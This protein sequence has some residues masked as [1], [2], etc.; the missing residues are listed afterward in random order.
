MP[1]L[2]RRWMTIWLEFRVALIN[3]QQINPRVSAFS[4]VSWSRF[5]Q[6]EGL[7]VDEFSHRFIVRIFRIRNVNIPVSDDYYMTV[8]R[9][10]WSKYVYELWIRV[11]NHVKRSIYYCHEYRRRV[12][13]P[14]STKNILGF[15]R[16]ASLVADL[17]NTFDFRLLRM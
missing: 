13:L 3:Q 8:F 16:F 11:E 5:Y 2:E 15:T 12:S 14:H 10:T 6:L 17:N 9:S 7:C 4:M 1:A